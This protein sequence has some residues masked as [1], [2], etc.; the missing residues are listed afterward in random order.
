M[1][2]FK[3]FMIISSAAS[4]KEELVSEMRKLPKP[5]VLCGKTVPEDLN[6][7]DFGT[8]VQLQDCKAEDIFTKF[9]GVLLDIKAEDVMDEKAE[10]VIGFANFVSA[11]IRRIAEL[12][13][14]TK[15][16]PTPEQRAAGFDKLNFGFFGLMDAYARRMGITDH[17]DV[18]K[19]PWIR[20]YKCMD[21][22]AQTERCRRRMEQQ[23]RSKIHRK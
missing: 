17:A 13:D 10:N 7:I 8:L 18:E 2:T 22:D 19:V 5:E 16:P 4:N 15:I 12:F 6:G 11:E 1:R 14:S 20:I 21:M 3:E 23:Q 9:P